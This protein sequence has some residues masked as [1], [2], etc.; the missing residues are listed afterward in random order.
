VPIPAF[1]NDG[2][3]PEGVHQTNQAEAIFRFG[4]GTQRR[5][6]LA[7]RVRH[8]LELAR[9][10]EA[11]RFLLNGSFVTVRSN[12]KDVDAVVLLPR[13][14]EEQL[15]AASEAALELYEILTTRQPAE[16]F[17]AEDE[18]D[19]LQWIEFF[20]RTREADGRRKGVVEILL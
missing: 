11:K 10:V 2:Y 12:P 16:L 14:F 13:T 7:L 19:W 1:R 3:L 4:S 15:E 8:W 17:A 6:M 5:R 20:T 9:K 18:S